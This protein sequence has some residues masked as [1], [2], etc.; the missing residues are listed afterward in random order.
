MILV[1]KRELRAGLRFGEELAKRQSPVVTAQPVTAGH[2]AHPMSVLAT[3]SNAQSQPRTIHLPNSETWQGDNLGQPKPIQNSIIA[4]NIENETPKGVP[5]TPQSDLSKRQQRATM[6]TQ[7]RR[8]HEWHL[9]RQA[10]SREIQNASESQIIVIDSDSEDEEPLPRT[11][12]EEPYSNTG[13]VGD[14]TDIW[15]VE[16]KGSSPGAFVLVEAGH[17]SIESRRKQQGRLQ[18]VVRRPRRSLIPSQW[19]RGEDVQNPQ[20][21][22]TCLSTNMDEVSGLM[23]YTEPEGKLR[24]GAGAIK[25]QQLRQRS[26]SGKFDIDLMAGTPKKEIVEDE[27]LDGSDE[28]D[29]GEDEEP[30]F[31]DSNT[32]SDDDEHT[33]P[34]VQHQQGTEDDSTSG[35]LRAFTNTLSLS[36]TGQDTGQF[37]R[38]PDTRI[39]ATSTISCVA[40]TA[41]IPQQIQRRLSSSTTNTSFRHERLSRK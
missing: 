11:Q 1:L 8:E 12:E 32:S 29:N 33:I 17:I 16:A 6:D 5:Q 13:D 34:P 3:S 41:R 21:Q 28:E 40:T 19:K 18:D 24:S 30:L 14:E 37:Q 7:A 25:R 36:T 27:S 15:L 4:G 2:K 26:N 10:I 22:S 38:L 23:A 20:E 9:E 31:D 39:N 35:S